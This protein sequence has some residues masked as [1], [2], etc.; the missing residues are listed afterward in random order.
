MAR[1]VGFQ[2]RRTPGR[3]HDAGAQASSSWEPVLERSVLIDR[4]A[5]ST[6]L[7]RGSVVWGLTGGDAT[8]AVRDERG[9]TARPAP[10]GPHGAFLAF[11]G[12]NLSVN[13]A[14]LRDRLPRRR[15]VRLDPPTN[16]SAP[17]RPS[18][19]P[20][21]GRRRGPPVDLTGHRTHVRSSGWPELGA[22]RFRTRRGQ[23]C[24]GFYGTLIDG[25]VGNVDRRLGLLLEQDGATGSNGCGPQAQPTK[26][27]P[28]QM[29]YG[30]G[31]YMDPMPEVAPYGDELRLQRGRTVYWGRA[32]PDVTR[33]TMATPRDVRTI[34][35][36]G[37][38][39]RSS[40]STTANSAPGRPPSRRIS[41]T[42][43]RGPTARTT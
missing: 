27:W 30:G 14:A 2:R 3:P 28:L 6:P 40:S 16:W 12:P 22:H 25:H 4:P 5:S 29:G 19:L 23:W 35:P 34:V 32:L 26:R 33:I 42:A 18:R 13:D 17:G 10:S 15:T 11:F 38:R 21:F 1:S 24:V 8:G 41:R 7:V 43:A 37:Q 36:S 39:M 31:S 9:R 20:P